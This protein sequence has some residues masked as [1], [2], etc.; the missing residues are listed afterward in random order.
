VA[1]PALA[2]GYFLARDGSNSTI[3]EAADTPAA[4]WRARWESLKLFT[5]VRCDSLPAERSRAT[6]WR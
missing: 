6:S 3:L 5:P 1:K 2:I 4:A